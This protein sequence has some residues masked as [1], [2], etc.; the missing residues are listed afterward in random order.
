L[1]DFAEVDGGAAQAEPEFCS[2]SATP[3]T[4]ARITAPPAASQRGENRRD[5]VTLRDLSRRA[6]PGTF[7]RQT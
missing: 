1:P 5:P 4:A 7:L 3:S 2:S 6:R